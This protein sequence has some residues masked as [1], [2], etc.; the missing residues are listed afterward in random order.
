MRSHGDLNAPLKTILIALEHSIYFTSPLFHF[1]NICVGTEGLRFLLLERRYDF[2]CTPNMSPEELAN[3]PAIVVVAY[4]AAFLPWT[5]F[6]STDFISSPWKSVRQTRREGF[7][8]IFF[9]LIPAAYIGFY[10]AIQ[11]RAKAYK[12][13]SAAIIALIFS[14]SHFMQAAWGLWQLSL[15]AKWSRESIDALQ[16]LG[17]KY[18][19]HSDRDVHQTVENLLIND[20]ISDN[21]FFQGDV[22]CY[23]QYGESELRFQY[24]A[25][26]FW[27]EHL[28][29]AVTVAR[30]FVLY[31]YDTTRSICGLHRTRYMKLVPYEPVEIWLNWATAFASQGLQEWVSDF[32]VSD[33]P[34]IS[35][36][37]PESMCDIF[38][39]R[40]HHFAAELLASA[41]MH[42]R[43]HIARPL[44]NPLLWERWR[45]DSFMADG[46]LKKKELFWDA[47]VAGDGLP[48]GASQTGNEDGLL[49]PD[50]CYRDYGQKLARAVERMPCR[51]GPSIQ[52]FDVAMLEWLTIALYIGR[53]VA[54]EKEDSVTHKNKG[55]DFDEPSCRTSFSSVSE[56]YP[57]DG[58][59]SSGE[60]LHKYD[61]A[62]ELLQRQ[63]GF[64]LE[65]DVPEGFLKRLMKLTAYPVR[66][67]DLV[68]ISASNRLIP[69][70]GEFIDCWLA[71]V[72][73]EQFSFLLTLNK[74]WRVECLGKTLEN[75]KRRGGRLP[76]D[77]DSLRSIHCQAE[78]ARMESQFANKDQMYL[79]MEQAVSFMGYSMESV[80][81]FLARDCQ[82]RDASPEDWRPRLWERSIDASGAPDQLEL[83]RIELGEISNGLEK[84]LVG[85]T[86]SSVLDH[87]GIRVALL[88]ELQRKLQS[89]IAHLASC[90]RT[91][92]DSVEAMILCLI[93][94][95]GLVTEM[96]PI[97]EKEASVVEGCG[98]CEIWLPGDSKTED[99][100][101]ETRPLFER[102]TLIF[103]SVCAPQPYY[104]EVGFSKNDSNNLEMWVRL[105][106]S[107]GCQE[108][109]FIWEWWRDAFLGRIEGMREWQKMHGLP[110]CEVR[111]TDTDIWTGLKSK[112]LRL[113]GTGEKIMIWEGWRPFRLG[114]CRFEL[115]DDMFLRRYERATARIILHEKLGES[116]VATVI[117]SVLKSEQYSYIPREQLHHCCKI[118]DYNVSSQED[119]T[120]DEAVG[121][122]T[123]SAARIRLLVQEAK[124]ILERNSW[125]TFRGTQW[126]KVAAL[127]YGSSEAFKLCFGALIS[128]EMDISGAAELL[129]SFLIKT[130]E[131]GLEEIPDRKLYRTVSA[132]PRRKL[133][134]RSQIGQPVREFRVTGD[135]VA[136]N[137]LESRSLFEKLL[138]KLQRDPSMFSSFIACVQMLMH[139]DT[140]CKSEEY[141]SLVRRLYMYSGDFSVLWSL[142]NLLEEQ[143]NIALACGNLHIFSIPGSG[144]GEDSSSTALKRLAG[145]M[146][147]RV[148]NEGNMLVGLRSTANMMLQEPESAV[149]KQC[150]KGENVQSMNLIARALGG[151][152]GAA[153]QDVVKTIHLYEMTAAA[154]SV[155]GTVMLGKLHEGGVAGVLDRDE[156]RAAELYDSV[157]SLSRHTSRNSDVQVELS[158]SSSDSMGLEWAHGEERA[159]EVYEDDSADEV[160]ECMYRLAELL[161]TRSSPRSEDHRRAFN[162][163]V[164][165]ARDGNHEASRM[166]LDS[167]VKSQ[168]G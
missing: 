140:P 156:E 96:K 103:K 107:E 55:I 105:A 41:A 61:G 146:Y 131:S 72:A 108:D 20:T 15:F 54:Q 30:V 29:A 92:A 43:P 37:D 67:E 94:F 110:S 95:S 48:F 28:R 56:T 85:K 142:G 166:F 144:E 164:R 116:K 99:C 62:L 9:T 128:K 132:T 97:K 151:R 152:M 154:G 77:C 135:K 81:T 68:P 45:S 24:E 155:H 113:P 1:L 118:V 98:N 6:T 32:V 114:F 104:A 168:K 21:Q 44:G 46:L 23:L 75:R 91:F 78:K 111:V 49:D 125:D 36:K 158:G 52:K 26:S 14:V 141:L 157:I 130:S 162:L 12:G 149:S 115:E 109:S 165:A 11:A 38:E 124:R 71:L 34:N 138:K 136:K 47:V 42:N 8:N 167:M 65:H 80:R 88:W 161:R 86:A 4:I 83:P 60:T 25:E 5:Y 51:F 64:D 127:E 17:I 39:A 18:G 10:I 70:A 53:Q 87:R 57:S 159:I 101:G 3:H 120:W 129:Q 122:R 63:L 66:G 33:P 22:R 119:T 112:R 50:K 7:L 133:G 2:P 137:W 93:S 35:D 13:M 121:I 145:E 123:T 69:Q 160:Y 100:S 102:Y 117:N 143:R 82:Y 106:R 40:R 150:T 27:R 16:A 58:G 126:L 90:R 19:Q 148:W 79:Y 89:E 139:F 31:V 163:Y 59:T 76:Q 73:G 74:D 147:S 84:V 153:A 134:G